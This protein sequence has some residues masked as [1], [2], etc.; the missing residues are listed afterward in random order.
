MDESSRVIADNPLAYEYDTLYDDMKAEETALR[1]EKL[2]KTSG[3]G[4]SKPSRYIESMVLQTERRQ[5]EQNAAWEKME[6]KDR[7]REVE[8]GEA[9]AEVES[10]ITES[11][12]K[13]IE[14]NSQN[15]LAT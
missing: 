3:K 9:S 7:V 13:Q 12:R 1:D 15:Q 11:Y 10:F 6:K 4:Q 14:L 2:A 5:R 8:T